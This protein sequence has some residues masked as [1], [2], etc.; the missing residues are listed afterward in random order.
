MDAGRGVRCSRCASLGAQRTGRGRAIGLGL[1][2][3]TVSSFAAS[4]GFQLEYGR[5][6]EGDESRGNAAATGNGTCAVA[7]VAVAAKSAELFSIDDCGGIGGAGF[8]AARLQFR[9]PLR[10]LG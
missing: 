10:R 8:G 9:A 5:G 2:H 3:A 7:V 1:S 4:S 6:L